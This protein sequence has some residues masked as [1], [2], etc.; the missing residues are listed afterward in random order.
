MAV[1]AVPVRGLLPNAH[2][3]ARRLATHPLLEPHIRSL[4]DFA[5][6]ET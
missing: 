4:R 3:L 1:E 2:A 6:E 5:P